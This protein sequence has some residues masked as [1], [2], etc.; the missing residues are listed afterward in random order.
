MEKIFTI[1]EDYESGKISEEE[2]QSL[3]QEYAEWI[4]RWNPFKI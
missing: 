2:A 3:K 4:D 1:N